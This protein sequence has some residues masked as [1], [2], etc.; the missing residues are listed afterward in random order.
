MRK[1]YIG[2]VTNYF[3]KL[4]VAEIRIEAQ[5]LNVGDSIQINGATTGVYEDNLKEIRVDLKIVH[6]AIKGELCSIPVTSLVRRND[7]LYKLI[8]ND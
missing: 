2:K 7:K 1:E 4:N 6:T 5:P 3:V 8:E